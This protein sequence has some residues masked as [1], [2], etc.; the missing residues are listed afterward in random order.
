MHGNVWEWVEDIWH[1]NYRGAPVE[2]SAWTEGGYSGRRVVRGGAWYYDPQNLRSAARDW[3]E[4]GYRLYDFGFRVGRTLSA[5]AG[6]LTVAPG[7]P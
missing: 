2:G 1:D 5:R 6:T 3:G 7:E 4:T